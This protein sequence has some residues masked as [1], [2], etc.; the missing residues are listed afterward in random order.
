MVRVGIG[1]DAHR[2]V[3]HRPLVLGGVE[4]PFALGLAGHSDADVVAHAIGDA[5]LGA[6]AL[7]DLGTHF[8]DADPKYKNISSLLLLEKILQLLEKNGYQ[9]GNIDVTVVLQ[10]PKVAPFIWDMRQKIARALQIAVDQVAVKAKTTEGM[11][12]TGTGEGISCYAIALIQELYKQHA[13]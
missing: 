4:I 3:A 13:G 5:L 9:I 11:G 2:L 8:P 6:A 7:G 1:Y 12:F 10:Q